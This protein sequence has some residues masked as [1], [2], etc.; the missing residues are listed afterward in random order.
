[1]PRERLDLKKNVSNLCLLI[2]RFE[3]Q[4][5]LKRENATKKNVSMLIFNVNSLN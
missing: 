2:L 3:K 5:S 1:M 4:K